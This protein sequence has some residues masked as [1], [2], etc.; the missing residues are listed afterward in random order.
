MDASDEKMKEKFVIRITDHGVEVTS[1][2]GR[3]L[4]FTACEALM[5]LDILRTE[6]E[7]L[8]RMADEAS[9]LPFRIE[10]APAPDEA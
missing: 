2:E 3:H 1:D 6:E 10:F 9:P 7:N 8:R 5:F 4:F